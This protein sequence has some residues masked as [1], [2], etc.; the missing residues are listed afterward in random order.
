MALLPIRVL[1]DPVLRQ[2]TKPVAK[3]TDELRQL[4]ASRF[5]T[6]HA[7]KGIGLAAPQVGRS[8]RLT[9]IE[10]EERQHVLINPEIVS[11]E[12]KITWEEG[13][14]SIPEVYAEVHRAAQVTVRATG[15]DG[16][17][18]SLGAPSAALPGIGVTPARNGGIARSGSRAVATVAPIGAVPAGAGPAGSSL[19][20]KRDMI[21]TPKTLITGLMM[22]RITATRHRDPRH[23]ASMRFG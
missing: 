6:M 12:G 17:T 4:A 3:V 20:R 23:H 15:L 9:V 10:I 19:R 13:C 14:L 21:G 8:E 5:E 16:P 22:S 7:A 18:P 1:G 2:P 11:S